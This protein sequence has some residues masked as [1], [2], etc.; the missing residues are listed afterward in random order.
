MIADFGWTCANYVYTFVDS[1]SVS[2]YHVF[3][4]AA[5]EKKIQLA[6][7]VSLQTEDPTQEDYDK[8]VTKIM[9]SDCL[10]TVIVTQTAPTASIIYEA[11][12]RGYEGHFVI[13]AASMSIQFNLRRMV[14]DTQTDEMLHGMLAVAPFNGAGNDRWVFMNLDMSMLACE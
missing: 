7:S 2:A 3:E 6:A 1:F 13:Q 10:A 11:R 4:R 8:A 9:Q 12:K 14:G 5:P